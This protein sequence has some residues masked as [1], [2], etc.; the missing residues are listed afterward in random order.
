M[1]KC[2]RTLSSL[3]SKVLA[4]EWPDSAFSLLSCRPRSGP[5]QQSQ[6]YRVGHGVARFSIL[7]S[8]VLAAEWPDSAF[9]LLLCTPRSGLTQH[10][11][12]D[13]GG[14]GVAG[15]SICCP[16]PL[17]SRFPLHCFPPRPSPS[18]SHVPPRPAPPFTSR[19][20]TRQTA[21]SLLFVF[22]IQAH[23]NAWYLTG[24]YCV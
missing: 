3:N 6:F 22:S 24:F 11:H 12:F 8:I 20:P 9:S 10:S 5:I 19:M 15:P 13:R 23:S 2:L 14:R 1:P 17:P 16:F 21:E 4:T 7:T 18:S